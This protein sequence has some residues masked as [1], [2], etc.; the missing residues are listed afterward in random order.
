MGARLRGNDGV[1]AG[2]GVTAPVGLL[3]VCVLACPA[4]RYQRPQLPPPRYEIAPLAPWD[5]GPPGLDSLEQEADPSPDRAPQL[6]S[7]SASADG[8]TAAEPHVG[9]V[10]EGLPK[11]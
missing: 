7:P 5:A 9:N 3:S 2:R 10:K 4:D 6:L 8:G 1:L 11:R